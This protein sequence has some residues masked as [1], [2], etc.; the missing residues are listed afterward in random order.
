MGSNPIWDLGRCHD[1][2]MLGQSGLLPKLRNITKP[3]REP[4]IIIYGDPAYGLSRNI[5]APFRGAVL[6]AEERQFNSAM[7]KVRVSVEWGFGKIMQNFAF[8][9]FKK[10]LKI[11]L[12]HVTKYYL[13]AG[14]LTNCHTCLYGS[15][16]SRFFEL[17]PPQLEVYLSNQ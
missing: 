12:Q 15:I 10:N 13:V 7:S 16:V 6:T 11:L 17:S 8:V 9:D 4:Y 1:A 3:N 2:F 5:L 14:I